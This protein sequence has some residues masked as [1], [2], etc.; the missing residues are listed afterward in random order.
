MWYVYIL[1]CANG[2]LYTGLTDD[3]KRRFEEHQ[4]GKGGHY[5][6]FSKPT[7]ILYKEIF[8]NRAQAE[9]REQQIKRWSKAKKL[10]LIRNDKVELRSLSKSRD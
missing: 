2:V 1:K 5:T 8:E 4:S 9:T 7:I 3:L 6:R 10:A